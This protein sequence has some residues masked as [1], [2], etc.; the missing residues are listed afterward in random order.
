MNDKA[1][2]HQEGSQKEAGQI[3]KGEEKG[4]AEKEKGEI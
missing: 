1:K 3:S 4:K 2:G